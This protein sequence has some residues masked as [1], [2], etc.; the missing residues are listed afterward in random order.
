MKLLFSVSILVY[1][2]MMCSGKKSFGILTRNAYA[3][4]DK[5]ELK[6]LASVYDEI[7]VALDKFYR[8]FKNQWFIENKTDE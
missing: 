6:K 7:L 2:S 3:K 5:N 8:D 4:K 1:F